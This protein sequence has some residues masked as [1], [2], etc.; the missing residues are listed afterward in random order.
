MYA[1]IVID[2]QTKKEKISCEYCIVKSNCKL[3]FDIMD[4]TKIE[5]EPSH[6]LVPLLC[7]Q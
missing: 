2:C 3:R 5:N 7:C 6:L 1:Q 4:A